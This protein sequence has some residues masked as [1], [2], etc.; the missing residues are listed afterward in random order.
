LKENEENCEEIEY[1]IVFLRKELKK[2]TSKLNIGLMFEKST[3]NLDNIIN[4]Q[5]YPFIKTSLGYDVVVDSI[6]TLDLPTTRE[7]LFVVGGVQNSF[8]EEQPIVECSKHIDDFLIP[9]MP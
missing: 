3:E 1:K 2:T 6:S 7:V 9:H 8:L 4:C 5:R